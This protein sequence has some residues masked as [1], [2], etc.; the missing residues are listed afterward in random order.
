[1]T[2]VRSAFSLLELLVVLALIAM[3]ACVVLPALSS[4]R[5]RAQAVTCMANGRQLAAAAHLYAGDSADKFPG[6]V[7][8]VNTVMND[9]RKPWVSGWL[10][11]AANGD[12][13]NTLLLT[14]NRFSSLARYCG[15]RADLF[16]CPADRHVSLP[17]RQRGWTQR[18]R[19][20]SANFYLGGA[21]PEAENTPTDPGYRLLTKFSQLVN[22][23]PALTWLY[24]DEHPDSINDAAFF[25]PR[26]NAW[27]D[28]PAGYHQ[29]AGGVTFADGHA[30]MHQWQ[31]FVSKV[32]VKI[33]AFTGFAAAT[34][35][36]DYAW[37][38]DRTPRKDSYRDR[39]PEE[40][41][42]RYSQNNVTP[43]RSSRLPSAK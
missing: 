36:P 28:L 3:L 2:R 38:W 15:N 43:S 12:N 8:S 1:M 31:G 13:T 29:G 39:H 7:H 9:P 18:A 21:N 34:T 30:E 16:R 4:A 32:V 25:A 20:I 27:V 42:G 35:D 5:L 40:V 33:E 37:L 14:D 19:S 17:Q 11:W 41:R 22:P 26:S 24:L 6:I 23:G 10:D